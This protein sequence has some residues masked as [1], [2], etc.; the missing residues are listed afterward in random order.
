MDKHGERIRFLA[1][2]ADLPTVKAVYRVNFKTGSFE[3]TVRC[4][5]VVFWH[6]VVQMARILGDGGTGQRQYTAEPKSNPVVV[7]K[8]V[9]NLILNS[10]LRD[11][12]VISE[13]ITTRPE[14]NLD[15]ARQSPAMR[16]RFKLARVNG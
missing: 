2:W 10:S 4:Y 12:G 14:R 16:K 15:A 8:P 13:R 6:M 11:R 5:S 1:R 7:K 9:C 3:P